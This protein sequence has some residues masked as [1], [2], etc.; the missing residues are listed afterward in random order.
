MIGLPTLNLSGRFPVDFATT[1]PVRT[2]RDESAAQE[3]EDEKWHIDRGKPYCGD[4]FKNREPRRMQHYLVPS[5][6]VI[7][8][9]K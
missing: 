6:V 1:A 3:E 7:P 2:C 4:C 5:C 9:R 8:R